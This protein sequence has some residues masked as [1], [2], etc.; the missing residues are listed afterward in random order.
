M[1]RQQQYRA[2]RRPHPDGHAQRQRQLRRRGDRVQRPF[3][4]AEHHGI[5]VVVRVSQHQRAA[6]DQHQAGGDA[7]QRHLACFGLWLGHGRKG[8]PA[9][10]GVE[11]S[12]HARTILC[13]SRLASR[14]AALD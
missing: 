12:E 4:A 5:E 6:P 10:P 7:Q 9:E 8:G 3:A 13:R 2:E 14:P 1:G 11:G